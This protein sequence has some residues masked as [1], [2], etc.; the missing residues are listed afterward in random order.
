MPEL[1]TSRNKWASA[2]LVT[3][4][5]I[6][7]YAVAWHFDA[8]PFDYTRSFYR[9]VN[10]TTFEVGGKTIPIPEQCYLVERSATAVRPFTAFSCNWEAHPFVD[11]TIYRYT[12][13]ELA[14]YRTANH[15]KFVDLHRYFTIQVARE[16]KEDIVFYFFP[17]FQI[18]IAS[19]Y[20][21]GA[22]CRLFV[23]QLLLKSDT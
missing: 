7:L 3:S 13:D 4:V 10:G 1:S 20:M 17:D 15:P 9:I 2:L 23:D 5:L 19:A 18:G 6:A 8:H 16:G 12:R 14:A 11:V 21:D 22:A